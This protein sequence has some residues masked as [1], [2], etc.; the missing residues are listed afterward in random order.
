MKIYSIIPAA[1]SGERMQALQSKTLIPIKG[2]PAIYMAVKKLCDFSDKVFVV[3]REE[4]QKSFSETLKGLPVEFVKGGATR[5]ESVQNALNK[6]E[7][8]N[9]IVLIHDGARPLISKTLIKNIIATA[10]EFGTAVPAVKITD[11]I[12]RSLD[13]NYI[14]ATV[15]RSELYTVQTPQAFR[16]DWL[17]EAYFSFSDSTTDDAALIEKL[18]KKIKMVQGERENIK[19]TYKEDI[20]LAEKISGF[21]FPTVGFGYDV[22]KL[23]EGRKLIL[24]GV[25]IPFDVATHA[26]I[27]ALLGAS[28]LGDIGSLFPDSSKEFK[29]I[30]SL[31]LLIKVNNI[32]AE[33]GLMPYNIDV[34]IAAQM[35][36]LF[37]FIP[38]MRKNIADA[39]NIKEEFVSVKA[40]TTERLG[41]E[42]RGEGIAAYA[43]A[44]VCR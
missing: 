37:P 6:I 36:K 8:L 42:G 21:S 27:D 5:R 28:A 23:T 32:L 3:I 7:D 14:G 17:K 38:A 11:T 26:V 10:K 18:G 24:G 34:T 16:A 22:H 39:L 40:T 2:I 1:G 13:G 29:D 41:F 30:N 20:A 15:D 12:K 31:S 9:S 33:H 19:L 44:S 35:P 25:E 4:E 43:V